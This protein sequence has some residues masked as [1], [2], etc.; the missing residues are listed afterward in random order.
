[1][2]FGRDR[3]SKRDRSALQQI[4]NGCKLGFRHVI[5]TIFD[6][7]D[8]ISQFHLR[9]EVIMKPS[10]LIFSVAMSV[11]GLVLAQTAT[12]SAVRES[13]DPAKIAD[14]ERRAQECCVRRRRRRTSAAP[15]LENTAKAT[16]RTK[17]KPEVNSAP[18][19]APCYRRQVLVLVLSASSQSAKKGRL[20]A[21]GR[22]ASDG[23]PATARRPAVT[24]S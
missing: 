24:R 8:G 1:M 11:S 4:D 17:D 21:F 10:A 6:P 15:R 19:D 18:S 2:L 14:I 9:S 12:D 3:R 22:R 13:T 16:K 5:R 20:A 7:D 23:E